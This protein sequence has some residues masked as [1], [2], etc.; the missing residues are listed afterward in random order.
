MAKE[1]EVWAEKYRPKTFDEIIN[2]ENTVERVKAFAKSKNIPHMLFAGPPGSG[3]CLEKGSLIFTLNGLK[4]VEE[5][6][7]G[8]KVLSLD[9]NGK[10][11]FHEVK[12][13]IGREDKIYSVETYSGCKVGVTFEHPFLTLENGL[14]TWKSVKELKEEDFVAKIGKNVAEKFGLSVKSE[15][16]N[17]VFP[18]AAESVRFVMSTFGFAYEDLTKNKRELKDLFRNKKGSYTEV[19]KIYETLLEKSREKIIEL[20]WLRAIIGSGNYLTE[21]TRKGEVTLHQNISIEM[22]KILTVKKLI[23][24]LELLDFLVKAEIFW[25]RIKRIKE[26]GY[27]KVYDLE[28][29]NSHNF[30]GGNGLILHN[31]T[32]ALVLAKELYGDQWRQNVLQM[33]ASVTPDTPIMIRRNGEIERTTIGK[34]ADEYFND[35]FSK[36]AFPKDVE[37]LSADKDFRVSF[38]PVKNISRHKVDK[39]ARIKFE[40]GEVKTTLDHSLIIL[41]ENCDLK[42]VKASELKEGDILISFK[43]EIDGDKVEL[44]LREFAPKKLIEIKRNG[45]VR[46]LRNTT[47]KKILEKI[48]ASENI[49]WFFGSFLAEGCISFRTSGAVIFTYGYPQEIP[50]VSKASSVVSS[51]GFNYSTHVIRSGSSG[52]RSGIQL[53]IPSTQLAR[54]FAKYFYFNGKK[55]AQFKKIPG[56][57]FNWPIGLRYSFLQGYMGDAAGK[58]GEYLRYSSASKEALIDLT[59]L[60]RISNLDT[61]FFNREARIVWRVPSYF[62]SKDELIPALPIIKFLERIDSKLKFNWRYLLR[63]Q[64]YSKKSKRMEKKLAKKILEMVEKLELNEEERL[65]LEKLKKLVNSNLYFVKIKKIE[66]EDYDGYVYDVSVPESEMFFG[67]TAPIL[68]HNSDARGI[69]V[70]RG[71]VKEF[72]RTVAIGDVP[73]KLIILDE[74]DAM[75]S[76]AQQALRRMMEMYASVSRMILIANYSNKIIEP[77]QS[78][79]AVFRFKALDDK[80]V[81]E[82]VDRIVKGEKL[83]ITEDGIKAIVRISEGDL[84]KAANI[85]Q[86]ASALKEKITE[87][88]VYEA[89]SLARPQEVKQMLEL[90]LSGKFM[91][92]RKMLEDMIIKKGLAGSD[93]VAEI[94]RQIP[95]LNIDD[96]AK[97]ELVEKCGEIDFRI[98]EGANELI[99]LESLLASFL[100]YAHAKGKK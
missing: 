68:L 30:V 58:W 87:D 17:D 44:D 14:P 85:L 46:F 10:F 57:V 90:A 73:F 93:I 88:V 94:H 66:I 75:T 79:C 83:K 54:F 82:F 42:S 91:E 24:T 15:N 12:G 23:T 36:Y 76:D 63:H 3:K 64:L 4:K 29:E 11:S 62:Y 18:F 37:I 96:R 86:V 70:I 8:Q 81:E 16:T 56:F 53:T 20:Q 45:K 34:L 80:H 13:I 72:A 22:I 28:I 21:F 5:I 48:E 98:S 25:D 50:L 74:A 31:T 65:Q 71:E 1:F 33:N 19:K 55:V 78:R 92:A 95:S 40:G 35:S 6:K 89:A 2:Q 99:Q 27:G 9:P 47:V 97:V 26:K 51:L 77:I 7:E 61:S 39:I 69:D 67:G 38:M 49:A 52:K 60:G 59:W 84:R 100:L 41:D 32:L 43:T